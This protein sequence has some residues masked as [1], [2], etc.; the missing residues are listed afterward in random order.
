MEIWVGLE[1]WFVWASGFWWDVCVVPSSNWGTADDSLGN[2]AM[3]LSWD[4]SLDWGSY[5]ATSKSDSNSTSS[6]PLSS[7]ILVWGEYGGDIL[8]NFIL[9]MG[10]ALLIRG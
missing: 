4:P 5:V 3:D 1:V 2:G 9:G 6:L 8:A 7:P 10:T